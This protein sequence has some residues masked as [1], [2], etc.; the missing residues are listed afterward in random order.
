MKSKEYTVSEMK[1]LLE[2]M[3]GMYD[4]ARIVD[5]IECRILQLQDDGKFSMNESCYG[6]WNA[7]QKCINC[8]SAAACSTGCHQEK[9]EFFQDQVFHIQSNPV[10]LKLPDG[11]AYDAVVEL[12]SI[13]SNDKAAND[14]EAENVDHKAA[15]YSAIHD[16]LTKVLSSGAFYELSRELIVKKS[17]KSWVMITANIMNFRFINALFGVLKGNEVLVRTGVAL[18][19][20]AEDAGGLC[21]RLGADQFAILLPNSK[22]NEEA[23]MNVAQTLR[24]T[25]NSGV[26]RFHIHFGV[27]QVADATIPISVMCGRANSAIRTIRENLKETIAYFDD[28]M[29]RKSL[30]EQEVL[31]AFED[32]LS[33]GEYKMY[34][35]P[36]AGAK[37]D[38][39]GAEALVRWCRP[40]G[41][42]IMPG[43]FIE[44]LEHAGLIH[45][46]DMYIWEQA[47]RQLDIWKG[48]DKGGLTI[49]VNMSAKDLYNVDVYMVLTELIEKYGVES[50]LLRLEITETALLDN[51]ENSNAI[52]SKL[53]EKGFLIE[54]D[55]FGKGYSSLSMLKDI[56]A[57]VLKIDM[58]L[59][60]EIESKKRSR[61][62]LESVISMA[63]SLGMDVITEGVETETQVMTLSDMGCLYFQGYYFSRPVTVEAF[64]QLFQGSK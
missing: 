49:S 50:K 10:T 64:E 5:P 48:T 24:T 57:D 60:Q 4:L 22:Y 51:P 52:I 43:E 11:G 32:A 18:N 29:M 45:E 26:Y 28:A 54:I 61:I 58:S 40:D 6:I 55:D 35:Q 42:V 17:D 25:F 1:T 20:I 56:H 21:G 23:L 7:G 16:E 2:H 39:F 63:D 13:E 62:I 27:Y 44:T 41:T 37:G 19:Q 9:D 46:L 3:S 34:L 36:L 59:L 38:I 47:V 53:R 31:S 8:S 14:R 15:Q 12:V 30:F 33:N